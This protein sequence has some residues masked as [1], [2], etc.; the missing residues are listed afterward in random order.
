MEEFINNLFSYEYFGFYIMIAIAVLA[1]LFLI[2]LVFGKKDQRKREIEATKRLE[3]VNDDAFKIDD[4]EQKVEVE[5]VSLDKINEDT[6]VIPDLEN[7]SSNDVSTED[8]EVEEKEEIVLDR[9]EEKPMVIEDVEE[10]SEVKE[11]VSDIPDFDIEKI[12]NEA[13]EEVEEIRNT[14]RKEVFSSV[15]T[16]TP[17]EEKE[18]VKEEPDYKTNFEIED[19]DFEMPV[20]KK[21]EEIKEE[22]EELEVPVINDYNLDSISGETYDIKE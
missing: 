3:L 10:T 9:V 18:E 13:N 19:L 22:K 8:D 15:F 20:L 5:D 21:T 2:V 14:E 12:M 6:I 16:E 11:E 4:N 7:L 17:K 1:V